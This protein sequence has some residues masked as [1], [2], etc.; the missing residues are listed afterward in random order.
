MVTDIREQFPL[1]PLEE[2]LAVAEGCGFKHPTTP[3]TAD[4]HVL[5]SDFVI[6]FQQDET[7]VEVV[8]TTKYAADLQSERTLEKLEIERRYWVS[9]GVDWGI[10]T[11]REI[12][13][14]LVK[15]VE[16][17]HAWHDFNDL[18]VLVQTNLSRIYSTLQAQ[19]QPGSGLDEACHRTDDRLGLP[20][21]TTLAAFRHGIATRKIRVDMNRL[22]VPSVPLDQL[23]PN[24]DRLPE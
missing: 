4:F 18:P 2:T 20:G 9:R 15:N 6:T 24:F 13:A 19:T 10:V 11:E 16:W 12:P 7:G 23:K 3:G 14:D 22:I 1:L 17:V 8:R 21:G 5:T